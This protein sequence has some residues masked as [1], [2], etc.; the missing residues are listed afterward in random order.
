[1]APNPLNQTLTVSY[2][3]GTVTG[4]R[5]LIEWLLPPFAL[6][7]TRT[8]AEGNNRKRKYGTLQRSS[9]RAGRVHH[10]ITVDGQRFS[11]RVTGSTQK[12]LDA[13]IANAAD[14]KLKAVHTQSGTKYARQFPVSV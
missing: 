11:V 5:G 1:M 4:A 10:L 14:S 8:A 9:A 3:G 6:K 12:F 2:A 13:V 7:W